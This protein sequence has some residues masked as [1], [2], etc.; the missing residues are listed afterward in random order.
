[1]SCYQM[2]QVQIGNKITI[3]TRVHQVKQMRIH[4]HK[5]QEQ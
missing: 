4:E 3:V 1:M 2:I 5:S